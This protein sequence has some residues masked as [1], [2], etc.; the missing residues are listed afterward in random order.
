MGKLIDCPT[1]R[2]APGLRSPRL[3]RHLPMTPCIPAVAH[4]AAT[5]RC[6]NL[7]RASSRS[8]VRATS[9]LPIR[10]GLQAREGELYSG[11]QSWPVWPLLLQPQDPMDTG[12]V[13]TQISKS[14]PIKCQSRG[15]SSARPQPSLETSLP[16]S[17]LP[18]L[19][20]CV[21]GG[22]LC[23]GNE[24]DIPSAH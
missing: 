18:W 15:V 7:M 22:E 1:L 23:R 11:V 19:L 6:C 5:K 14:T 24:V 10:S 13:P 17:R 12:S 3:P 4:A 8:H 2:V 20:L 16:R 21:S 9:C